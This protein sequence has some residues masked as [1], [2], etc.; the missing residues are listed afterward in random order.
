MGIDVG[1][2]L[3]VL[4]YSALMSLCFIVAYNKYKIFIAKR[5]KPKLV[6]LQ[7]GKKERGI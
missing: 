7:G 6:L 1:L 5:R 2:I 4:F 3:F